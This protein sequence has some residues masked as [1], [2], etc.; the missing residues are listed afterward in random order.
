M[1]A[2]H[3]GARVPVLAP[4]SVAQRGVTILHHLSHRSTA[5][6]ARLIL[7]FTSIAILPACAAG[8]QAAR[9]E[10]TAAAPNVVSLS[11]TEYTFQA[12]DT[13][14][15]G[16]VTFRVANHGEEIHYAHI[17]GLE[18]GRSVQDL[19]GA[20]AEAIRNSAPRPSW[21]KRFGGPGGTAPGDTSSVTQHL[22]PGSY[23]W[24]C[25][26][27]DSGGEPHFAKGEIKPLVVRAAGADAG[28]RAAAPEADLVIRLLDHS[29]AFETPVQAGRHT[30]RVENAGAEP[31]DL[32]LMKIAPGKSLEDVRRWLN[33]E[34]ARRPDQPEDPPPL[35]SMGTLA[36]GIATIA[37]GME[38]FFEADLTPGEYVL[39]CMVTAP[40]GRAHI[41]HGMIRQIRIPE[42]SA[43]QRGSAS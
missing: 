7:L 28:S 14:A 35:E 38:A 4:A 33:P 20:Y 3:F 8:D 43:L 24:I 36:G 10:Q 22:E 13:I 21:V 26:M 17:V 31:H 1:N 34:S 27:E 5:M 19:A 40:D 41:E 42:E 6:S 11:A 29:F 18:A 15:S 2:R 32:V 30:I 25:P 16:W 39:A 12:P 9:T 23:V 37:P